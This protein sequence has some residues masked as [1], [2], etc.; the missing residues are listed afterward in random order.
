MASRKAGHL[1][2]PACF[3]KSKSPLNLLNLRDAFC[4]GQEPAM[5]AVLRSGESGN[6]R[7]G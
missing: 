1:S 7:A 4:V 3:R 5:R 6:S 2:R